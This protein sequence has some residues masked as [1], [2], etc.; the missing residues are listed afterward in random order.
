VGTGAELFLRDE[1]LAEFL[2][3]HRH[4]RLDIAVSNEIRDIVGKGYDA[5]IQL[6][7]VI[8]R[9]MIAVPVS[10]DLRLGVVGAPV[11]LSRREA[12]RPEPEPQY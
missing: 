1:L 8:D 6:G 3:A 10:G 5:G 7:E 4:I 2:T 12:T 9:D 11:I